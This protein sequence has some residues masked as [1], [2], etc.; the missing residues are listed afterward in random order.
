MTRAQLADPDLVAK[1]RDGRAPRPCILCNERCK[2]RDNRNP[3]VSCV[4]EPRTGYEWSDPDPE[5]RRA[6]HAI[7]V[8]VVGAGPAG[9][10]AARVAATHG[11]RVNLVERSDRLGGEVPAAAALAGRGQL[12]SVVDWLAAECERLGVTVRT[13]SSMA[14][15][16]ATGAVIV[17]TGGVDRPVEYEIADGAVV[18]TAAAVAA[19]ERSAGP[20]AIWDPIGGPIGVALAETL[21]AEGLT[22]HL[23]SPDFVVG[24]QLS[25]TGDLAPT[26]TRLHQAG[27]SLHK[28]VLLRSVSPGEVTVEDRYAGTTAPV[29]ADWLVDAG[30]R[31]ADPTPWPETAI[32]VGD[33]VAPRTIAEAILEGR[34]AALGLG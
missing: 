11:H 3:L 34:R 20:V 1:L 5:V 12:S 29:A 15:G 19:G 24:T 25:L 28:R 17:A 27:V 31:L 23:L 2:V 22:V 13:G 14:P 9:L 7:E 8:T 32:R 18:L 6:A 21:A 10:E 16:A 33:A 26:N 4:V 30:H